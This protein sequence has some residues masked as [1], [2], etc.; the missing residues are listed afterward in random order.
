MVLHDDNKGSGSKS[1]KDDDTMEHT[2][3]YN[4]DTW[5]SL[6]GLLNVSEF[7]VT[8][9][10]STSWRKHLAWS[11][12][13]GQDLRNYT[14]QRFSSNMVFMSLILGTELSVLFNSSNI[15]T[16]IREQ[17]MEG[18][19][20]S[21]RHWIGFVFLLSACVTVI[22][23]VATFTA[24]GMVNAIGDQN[25]HCLL[26]SSIGQLV[27]A[28]PSNFAV[29]SLYL[30]LLCLFLLIFELMSGPL[31]AVLITIVLYLFF[32]V[33]ISLSAFGRLIIHTGAMSNR[34]VLDPKLERALLP[35]GL[36]ASLLIKAADRKRR[37]TSVVSMYRTPPACKSQANANL[38]RLSQKGSLHGREVH[39]GDFTS[40]S[41]L[42]AS[43]STTSNRKSAFRSST[44]EHQFSGDQQSDNSP[45]IDHGEDAVVPSP[46]QSVTESTMDMEMDESDEEMAI[47]KTARAL[48]PKFPSNT[49]YPGYRMAPLRD[50]SN[51]T[52][53]SF[54]ESE[55]DQLMSNDSTHRVYGTRDRSTWKH[56][57]DCD[58]QSC[59]QENFGSGGSSRVSFPRASILNRSLHTTEL[60]KVVQQ[61]LSLDNSLHDDNCSKGNHDKDSTPLRSGDEKR[62]SV[63][64]SIHRPNPSTSTVSMDATVSSADNP[65]PVMNR[66]GSRRSLFG[67]T[68]KALSR[69]SLLAGFRQASARQYIQQEWNE[70]EHVRSMYNIAPPAEVVFEEEEEDEVEETTNHW[71]D[72]EDTEDTVG[73]PHPNILNRIKRLKS[74]RRLT[75]ARSLQAL[76]QSTEKKSENEARREYDDDDDKENV[77]E[78]GE[79]IHLLSA[80]PP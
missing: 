31:Q 10:H 14:T 71:N 26:R 40:V 56:H 80:P 23:L 45:P 49:T 29:A 52:I 46:D 5:L 21:L 24:W 4:Q 20:K 53:K 12:P 65:V 43:T 42:S 13:S 41:S 32:Q 48:S 55:T 60:K 51:S 64:F 58:D 15:T 44:N 11:K 75:S 28:L 8:V 68:T 73:M 57:G 30:F 7:F 74:L 70:E 61:A 36:H 18:N 69:R 35:S 54:A 2:A 76:M 27:T 62:Q 50:S 59:H 38:S 66:Q 9:D 1:H 19:I 33:V 34:P 25:T 78:T 63:R 39:S 47:L 67:A 17:M 6:L 16:D 3:D 22:A 72:D 37:Q 77:V 79:R